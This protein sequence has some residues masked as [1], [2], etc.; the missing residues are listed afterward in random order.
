MA[1]AGTKEYF[2]KRLR[3]LR[4]NKRLSQAEVA[5]EI[6][7][8][9][10]ANDSSIDSPPIKAKAY[11]SWEQGHAQ[12]TYPIIIMIARYYRV[13]PM[14]L[15]ADTVPPDYFKEV[16]GESEYNREVHGL[17]Q[18]PP[19][20][21]VAKET[22]V[23]SRASLDVDLEVVWKDKYIAVLEQQNAM[24]KEIGVAAAKAA[25]ERL[26]AQ[27]ATKSEVGEL[28]ASLSETE[29]DVAGHRRAIQDL[30]LYL[31][32]RFAAQDKVELKV[33]ADAIDN[34]VKQAGTGQNTD[35]KGDQSMK[36]T[37]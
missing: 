1:M 8:H 18:I 23:G 32:S 14:S 3:E 9:A 30:K 24:N 15:L 17:P 12:P 16:W 31:V 6:S 13:H 19:S 5:S 37:A 36:H 21:S 29:K 34:P 7:K 4:V 22:K 35:K 20:G 26:A 28:A 2:S 33:I 10:M 25:V 27:F 11:A